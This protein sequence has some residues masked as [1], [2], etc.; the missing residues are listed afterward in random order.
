MYCGFIFSELAELKAVSWLEV[1][2][3]MD[4]G[5]LSGNTEYIVVFVLKFGERSYGWKELPIKFS[6]T[7]PDGKMS[8]V[9]IKFSVTTPYEEE[10][11]MTRDLVESRRRRVH[12]NVNYSSS[13]SEDDDEDSHHCDVDY[14][15]YDGG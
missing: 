9:E 11:E 4:C 1:W 12:I 6:I 2:G 14:C 3:R 15:Y 10:F 13:E 7:T 5:I 8:E